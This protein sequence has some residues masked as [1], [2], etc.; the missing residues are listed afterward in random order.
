MD[1]NSKCY[2]L[3]ETYL[4]NY[5]IAGDTLLNP[6]VTFY[7]NGNNAYAG[8]EYNLDN[9][10]WVIN[11]DANGILSISSLKEGY[12][13]IAFRSFYPE[14]DIDATPVEINF[15]IDAINIDFEIE[16]C[17]LYQGN[18]QNVIPYRLNSTGELS[19]V[20]NQNEITYLWDFGNGETEINIHKNNAVSS[21]CVA[22][23]QGDDTLFYDVS[24]IIKTGFSSDSLIKLNAIIIP[25]ISFSSGGGGA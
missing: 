14:G 20:F 8:I 25:P 22:Y 11:T 17:N 3:P 7:L 5:D 19:N 13:S 6:S 21:K 12:H 1:V 10:Y 15:F 9:T 24:L 23:L 16:F 4:I 18:Q 2:E